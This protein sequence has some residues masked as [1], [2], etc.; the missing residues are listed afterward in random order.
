MRLTNVFVLGTGRCG[1]VT[2][3]RACSRHLTNWSAGHETRAKR[4]GDDRF[5]YPK[6]HIEVDPRL[7][8][9]LGELG[10]RFPDALFV[11]LH[12]NV[13]ATA[14]SIARRWNGSRIGFARVF[15]ESMLMQGEVADPE[16]RLEIAR[17]QVRTM[18]AN[19]EAALAARP[20][21]LRFEIALEEAERVFPAFLERIGAEGNL[22]AAVGEWAVRH[23]ASGG[24]R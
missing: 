14:R 7:P 19:I 17:F 11:H 18:R 24:S 13:E 6:R 15:G 9:F 10:D 8:W 3:S 4:L 2:F 1:T 12:R 16:R 23:N 5:R 20:A 21:E 22:E